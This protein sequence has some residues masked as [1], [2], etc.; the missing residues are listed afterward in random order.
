MK[1]R[2]SK[3]WGVSLAL[4]LVATLILAVLPV[5]A[6]PPPPPPDDNTWGVTDVGPEVVAYE[7]VDLAA[8]YDGKLYAVTGTEGK[9]YY[10]TNLGGKWSSKTLEYGAGPTAF[11]G[12]LVAVAPNDADLVVVVDDEATD[13]VYYTTD[14]GDNFY[15]LGASGVVNIRAVAISPV[16]SNRQYVVVAGDDG[17][18]ATKISYFNLSNL[19]D[20]WT[21]IN[22]ANI[23]GVDSCAAVAFS[24]A[25]ASDYVMVAVTEDI[26]TNNKAF[27]EIY[28]FS[29]NDWNNNAAFDEYV[30]AP[31]TTDHSI[32]TI[33]AAIDSAEIALVPTYY[34][35]DE[36]ERVAFVGISV[37]THTDGGVY[38]M[39]NATAKGLK[40][41]T[42]FNSVAV[43]EDGALVAG[44]Y[45]DNLVWRV[46]D[47]LTA[48]KITLYNSKYQRPGGT[49][50]VTV[51]WVDDAVVATTQ[52]DECAFAVSNDDGMS[53]NDTSLINTTINIR[54]LYVSPDASTLWATSD[55][56]GN[57]VSV[58]RKSGGPAWE[59][60]LSLQGTAAASEYIVRPAP[61][62]MD[63]VYLAEKA[64]GT[65]YY[66]T[67]AGET[68]WYLR[69]CSATDFSGNIQDIAVESA[70]IVYALDDTGKVSKTD[71]SGF[72]WEKA[73][74]TKAGA[75]GTIVSLGE[76]LLVVGGT[77]VY[78][79]T[80]GNVKWNEVKSPITGN[81]LQVCATGLESDD[82]IFAA[83]DAGT[84]YRAPVGK[85]W[86][87]VLLT[88][89]TFDFTGIGLSGGTL[90]A[91]ADDATDS[92]CYRTLDP[93]R[94]VGGDPAVEWSEMD[95]AGL[96]GVLFDSGPSALSLSMGSV[97]LWAVDTTAAANPILSLKDIL[98]DNG[99]APTEPDNAATVPMNTVSGAAFDVA[100]NWT[101][102]AEA[103]AYDFDLALDN[104]FTQIVLQR[105]INTTNDNI[106]S[107][108][109]TVVFIVG[110]NYNNTE[111][112]GKFVYMPGTTYYWRVRVS[113][114]GPVYSPWSATRSFTLE[115]LAAEAAIPGILA[116]AN[117]GSGVILSPGFSWTPIPT[118]DRYEFI[119]GTDP[120]FNPPNTLVSTTAGKAGI[121][122]GVV[123][124]Y[125]TTYYWRVRAA[126]PIDGEWSALGSFTTMADPAM[127]APPAE[128]TPP[129]VIE[130]NPIP[131]IELPA[132][133]VN[134]P[135]Q[136]PQVIPAPVVNV[137]SPT[138]TTT[139]QAIDSG[140]ILAII[141]IGAVL[142]IAVVVLI[143]RTRRP[144]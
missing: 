64:G 41:G 87:T 38:R 130:Q 126:H 49:D 51:D 14:G 12:N 67:D 103:T 121:N 63:T 18:G 37:D 77:K 114:D 110:P 54:D 47:A 96:A 60:V 45:D 34:G 73:V 122:P 2:I 133:I 69:I 81:P 50:L 102:I 40:T 98:T 35:G 123:L 117:G 30:Y 135:A 128:P 131:V 140:Y 62:D 115:E 143:V 29:K 101:R 79:S 44:Q 125:S 19:L 99:P 88:D 84:I 72:I 21:A 42:A 129:V 100:F 61:D 23:D 107:T 93:T 137:P 134:I 89:A 136:Q 119:L 124:D 6:A 90:Y 76:D 16:Q 106:D 24:P 22:M 10:S 68:K 11:E 15:D 97:K 132:P 20:G 78:Y 138:V 66:S 65:V 141:I 4:V 28:S 25:F 43:R 92:K 56:G 85:D 8:A 55:D 144:V 9:L 118:V 104:E 83:T 82:Y 113:E 32:L 127:A 36:I 139:G 142:V 120:L 26:T 109:S 39:E 108:A 105:D 57:D 27:F 48:T 3:I 112:T 5:S 71:N 111:L 70:E 80:D 95:T 46:G 31:P 52:N 74:N 7:V 75:G 33:A 86:E 53:F 17:A 13:D 116:P 94:S 91:I 1:K 58:W 59:R